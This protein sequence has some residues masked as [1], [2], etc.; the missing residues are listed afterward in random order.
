MSDEKPPIRVNVGYAL[1][2]LQRALAAAGDITSDR[3][4]KW[5]SVIGGV[6]DGT[7]RVGS[8]TPLGGT[9]RG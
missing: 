4:Q 1:S 2:Q 5:R 9:P 3:V 8:R 6:L 7:I